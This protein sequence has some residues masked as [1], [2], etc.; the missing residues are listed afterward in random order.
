MELHCPLKPNATICSGDSCPLY[1]QHPP[2]CRLSLLATEIPQDLTYIHASLS[3]IQK[4]LTQIIAI[5]SDQKQEK[6]TA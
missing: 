5:I 2:W 4:S 6:P 3:Y 1:T